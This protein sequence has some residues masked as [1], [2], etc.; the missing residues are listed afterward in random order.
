MGNG[1]SGWTRTVLHALR[2]L[3]T[4]GGKKDLRTHSS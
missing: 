1:Q 3:K 2:R 4:D